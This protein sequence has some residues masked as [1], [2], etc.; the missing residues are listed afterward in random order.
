[1]RRFRELSQRDPLTY[2]PK[3]GLAIY[4]LCQEVMNR[5]G[6]VTQAFIDVCEEGI[7]LHRRLLHTDPASVPQ[8]GFL[9]G[10][11]G[12]AQLSLGWH[13]KARPLIEESLDLMRRLARQDSHAYEPSLC[14]ALSVAA[15]ALADS[16]DHRAALSAARE[17]VARWRQLTED[18]PGVHDADL[19]LAL[20]T[21]CLVLQS[22]DDQ[23]GM[24][25]PAEESVQ[26]TRRLHANG[27]AA[28][29]TASLLATGLDLMVAALVA[30][31]RWSDA[32]PVAE[33]AI[34]WHRQVQKAGEGSI[35][36][37][38]AT[39][40]GNYS[41]V[42]GAI[43]RRSEAKLYASEAYLECLRRARD[44]NTA[45]DL[46]S[47]ASDIG[48]LLSEHGMKWSATVLRRTVAAR[49][50]LR[51]RGLRRFLRR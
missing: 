12:I 19:A 51:S 31:E 43:G 33:E 22:S 15:H 10:W 16:G 28:A 30:D 11:L 47:A 23:R 5:P 38:F 34:T 49:L 36:L 13:D 40:L 4:G 48:A 45:A 42:L 7:A 14:R 8:L 35:S 29:S 1:M 26:I 39:S 37:S 32:A 21:L 6:P 41:K 17:S 20:H 18:I 25:V 2:E 9:L 3:L 44:T 24:L 50:D 27:A 46:A